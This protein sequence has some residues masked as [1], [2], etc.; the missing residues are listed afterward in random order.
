[1]SFLNAIGGAIGSTFLTLGLQTPISRALAFGTV[2]FAYQYLLRPSLSYSKVE[3]KSGSQY[4]AKEFAL[5]SSKESPVPKTYFPWYFWPV[6]LALIG[7][8][9]L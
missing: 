1:M 7:G 5:F 2:G 3:T 4:V 6:L 9:F 8:L